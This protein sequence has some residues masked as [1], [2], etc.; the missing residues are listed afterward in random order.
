[1]PLLLL[2]GVVLTPLFPVPDFVPPPGDTVPGLSYDT[3]FPYYLEYAAMTRIHRVGEEPGG[4]HG[5]AAFYLKGVE[6]VAGAAYPQLQLAPAD[7]DLSDPD[8]G[9]GVSVNKV[10]RNVNWVAFD[11]MDL[12]YNGGL[13]PGD[14]VDAEAVTRA[15]ERVADAGVF[16]GVE[17]HGGDAGP[18]AL[19]R[20]IGTDFALRFGRDVA[21]VRV[22]LTRDVM[23][24][25]VAYLN[26]M[27]SRY[28]GDPDLDFV[29]DGV[30]DNCTHL[31][32]NALARVSGRRELKTH[33]GP[34]MRLF[35]LAIP[36]NVLVDLARA[37][38]RDPARAPDAAESGT[39]ARY[40]WMLRQPGVMVRFLPRFRDRNRIWEGEF[41]M[42]T[43]ERPVVPLILIPPMQ[44]VPVGSKW[45]WP[46]VYR[47]EQKAYRR[48]FREPRLVDLRANLEDYLRA[49]EGIAR[50]QTAGEAEGADPYY[51]YL[52]S[53]RARMRA[54]LDDS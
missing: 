19:E 4:R 48:L 37:G 39:L 47:F 53:M 33:A 43:M 32:V 23:G 49:T 9:V 18:A 5:H 11:G 8:T 38:N 29:W 31:A 25:I 46:P 44:L 50:P 26:A 52:K 2:A 36:A 41:D 54:A 51:D 1:V 20:S 17:F 13:G 35:N 42:Y 22:P 15:I 21:C 14:A 10:L 24:E 34:V 16:G 28:A 27:N 40:Q 6:R 7:A 12:F 30:E 45:V 3:L